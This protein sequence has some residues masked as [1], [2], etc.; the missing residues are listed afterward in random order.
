[1][2]EPIV[3]TRDTEGEP[4]L[5]ARVAALQA[6]LDRAAHAFQAIKR[7]A[8]LMRELVPRAFEEGFRL[9]APEVEEPW[10]VDWLQSETKRIYDA[11]IATS[12][13]QGPPSRLHGGV[14][15]DDH[16]PHSHDDPA[17]GPPDPKLRV[18]T[19]PTP[20]D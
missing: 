6:E 10:L 12:A 20:E 3:E 8:M 4:G 13:S 18:S 11:V 19:A 15:P 2:S 14:A 17:E 16:A 7:L 9:R 1:M 5:E